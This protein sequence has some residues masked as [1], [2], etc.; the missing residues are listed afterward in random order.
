MS[1]EFDTF[2]RD[3]QNQIYDE[4]RRAYGEIAFERWLNPLF[5]GVM[6]NADGYGRVTGSCGDTMEIFL[7]FQNDIVKEASFQTDGCGSSMICGSF[8][9]EMA[10]GKNPDELIEIT[11][12]KILEILQKFPKEDR[13]CAFLAADTLQEALNNYMIKGGS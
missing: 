3:L 10:L 8:A 1:D 2:A 13:H 4:T 6:E 7:K 5:V 9:V 12:E 11:G